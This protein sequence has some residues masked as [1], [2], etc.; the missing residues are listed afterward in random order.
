MA[1]YCPRSSVQLVFQSPLPSGSALIPTAPSPPLP[2]RHSLPSTVHK[3][4]FL[5]YICHIKILRG[6]L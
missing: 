1:S 5:L 3:D 4:V 6:L 2:L